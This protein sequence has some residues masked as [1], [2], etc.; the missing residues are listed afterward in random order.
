MLEDVGSFPDSLAFPLKDQCKVTFAL[1]STLYG[2]HPFFP[3]PWSKQSLM[4]VVVVVV[5]VDLKYS[6]ELFPFYPSLIMQAFSNHRRVFSEEQQVRICTGFG[7][8]GGVRMLKN[9]FKPFLRPFPTKPAR[10]IP[11]L[12]CAMFMTLNGYSLLLWL[13]PVASFKIPLLD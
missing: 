12:G 7:L 10:F 4:L 11:G 6:S 5:L 13:G 9:S 3:F 2:I 8:N 1:L